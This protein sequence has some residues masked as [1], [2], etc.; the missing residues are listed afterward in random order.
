MVNFGLDSNPN[1]LLGTLPF[2]NACS[3]RARVMKPLLY[4]TSLKAV[5]TATHTVLQLGK[6]VWEIYN[7]V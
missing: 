2:V 3:R 4:T 5:G 6:H 1:D 7:Q